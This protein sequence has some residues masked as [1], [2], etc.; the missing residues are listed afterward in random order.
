MSVKRI[1]IVDDS[2]TERQYLS[3]V[4]TECGYQCLQAVNGEDGIA[5]ARS[6]HPDLIL[7]DVVMPGTN[8]YQATR[9]L[10]RDPQTQNIPIMLCTS[11]NQEADKV[12]GLRQGAFAYFT[13]PINP[14]QLF[15]CISGLS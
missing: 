14:Q 5:K 2:M 6:E 7:M 11:K 12:W 10:A 4:L 9:T 8:G 15:E 1:L 3:D 13:K